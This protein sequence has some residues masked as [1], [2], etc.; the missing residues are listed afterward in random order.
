MEEGLSFPP[1]DEP[2]CV[3]VMTVVKEIKDDRRRLFAW[4]VVYGRCLEA[5]DGRKL[6]MASEGLWAVEAFSYQPGVFS[7]NPTRFK[8]TVFLFSL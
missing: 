8:A 3:E 2:G 4:T 7:C 5:E 1:S 6:E